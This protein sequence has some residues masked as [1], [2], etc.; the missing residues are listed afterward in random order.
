[1]FMIPFADKPWAAFLKCITS[2]EAIYNPGKV[3]T[4]C[5]EAHLNVKLSLTGNKQNKQNNETF[6]K[7]SWDSE[8]W[9]LDFDDFQKLQNYFSLYIVSF[10][11]C[12]SLENSKVLN[13]LV[14]YPN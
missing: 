2:F 5:R 4:H 13:N 1:M 10:K 12:L 14:G 9:K 6:R 11:K 8:T 7:H 3:P